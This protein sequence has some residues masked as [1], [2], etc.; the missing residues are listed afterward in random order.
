MVVDQPRGRFRDAFDRQQVLHRGAADRLGRAEMHAAARACGSGRCRRSRRAGSRSSPS[1]AGPGAS[2]W[3]SGAP[4]RAAA[5]RNRAPGRAPAARTARLPVHEEALAAGLAV[6]ALGD[7]DRRDTVAR[8][9]ARP[10]SRAPPIIW[11]W[12]PSIR[13]TSGQAGKACAVVLVVVGAVGAGS[14]RHAP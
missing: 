10:G 13:M 1:C 11:P 9:R 4:R 12:P 2:R 14:A 3:R 6:R 8:C 7:A 5:G